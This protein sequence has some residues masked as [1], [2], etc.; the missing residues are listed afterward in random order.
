MHCGNWNFDRFKIGYY[1]SENKSNAIMQLR[2]NAM[3]FKELWKNKTKYFELSL[4][5]NTAQILQCDFIKQ[6][7]FA[8]DMR[9]Q[10]SGCYFAH[11]GEK[12]NKIIAEK[13]ISELGLH[14]NE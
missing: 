2:L 12:T 14:V 8:R 5:K 13:I 6:I 3:A 11:P 9:K 4:Y 1:W 10:K 7:D